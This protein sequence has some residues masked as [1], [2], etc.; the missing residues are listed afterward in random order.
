MLKQLFGKF[1]RFGIVGVANTLIYYSL[2]AVLT[3]AGLFYLLSSIVAFAIS[4]ANAFYWNNKHVFFENRES[5]NAVSSAFRMV[6]SYAFSGFVVGSILLYILVDVYD[7]SEYIAPLF[8]LCITVP[9]NFMLNRFWVF[10]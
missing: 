6:I 2:Y 5:R 9:L 7:V 8:G 4:M 3:Y 1:W 10:R